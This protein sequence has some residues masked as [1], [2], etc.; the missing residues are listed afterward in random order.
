MFGVFL[1]TRV[2][3]LGYLT[4]LMIFQMFLK[5]RCHHDGAMGT[6]RWWRSCGWSTIR[7]HVTWHSRNV[8]CAIFSCRGIGKKFP[9]Y[10]QG[11]R[12]PSRSLYLVGYFILINGRSHKWVSLGSF[13]PEISGV[14]TAWWLF[15]L[16]ESGERKNQT[17]NFSL[18]L[19]FLGGFLYPK[20]PQGPSN[21]G[22]NE[23]V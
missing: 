11:G 10:Q 1:K 7:T 23:P 20:D 6:N 15:V 5:F 12:A 3:C 8:H 9:K 19:G 17:Y 16:T 18:Y 21:G 13:H 4:C 2:W 14:I 22:V